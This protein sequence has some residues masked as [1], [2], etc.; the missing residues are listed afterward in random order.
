VFNSDGTPTAV[1]N[2]QT[3]TLDPTAFGQYLVDELSAGMKGYF[4]GQEPTSAV[5]ALQLNEDILQLDIGDVNAQA[6]PAPFSPFQLSIP[7]EATA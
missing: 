1:F 6:T 2:W 4:D 7:S 5:L 3:R